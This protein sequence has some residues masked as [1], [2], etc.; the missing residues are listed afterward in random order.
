MNNRKFMGDGLE[1]TAWNIETYISTIL[2]EGEPQFWAEFTYTNGYHTVNW[3]LE[4]ALL[5]KEELTNFINEATKKKNE[6]EIEHKK[7]KK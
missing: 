2:D 7:V 6:F 1:V 3:D 4:Q 5:L